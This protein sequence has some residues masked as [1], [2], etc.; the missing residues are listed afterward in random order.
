MTRLSAA[1][2]DP[3]SGVQKRNCVELFWGFTAVKSHSIAFRAPRAP[4]SSGGSRLSGIFGLFALL[5]LVLLS[6]CAHRHAVSVPRAPQPARIGDTET[7][8]ASWY[9]YPYHGRRAADGEIYDMEQL[10]AAH[11]TLPFGTWVAVHDLDNGKTVNV[12]IIDRGP[13][14]AGRII[15]LSRAA[16]R[17]I[18]MIG[19]GL[20]RVRL[21][22]IP[23]QPE[24]TPRTAPAPEVVT[25]SA[26]FAV[27]VG[28]FQDR[29]RAEELRV[30]LVKQY[31]AAEVV[32]RDGKPV[33]WRVLV[34][35]ESAIESANGLA[36]RL[37]AE[38][39]GLSQTLIVRLDDLSSVAQ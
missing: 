22:I 24:A 25:T 20:A 28:A 14:V 9:G 11:R 4:F 5:A 19:P 8:I 3:I 17:E 10:V 39:T 35:R 13:F 21:E 30:R 23:P 15:D 18:D 12:R 33:L 16:A 7:G 36:V 29:D 1:A 6:G 2:F 38:Q 32:R 27:Q 37:R 31:G 26:W 34:G